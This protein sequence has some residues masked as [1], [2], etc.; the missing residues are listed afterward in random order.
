MT[1]YV[2]AA[3]GSSTSN[4]WN[5]GIGLPTVNDMSVNIMVTV[6]TFVIPSDMADMPT[7]YLVKYSILLEERNNQYKIDATESV[8]YFNIDYNLNGGMLLV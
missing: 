7:D 6:D 4:N 3:C 2:Y 8:K 1:G 5:P